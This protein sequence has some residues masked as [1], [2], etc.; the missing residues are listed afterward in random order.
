MSAAGVSAKGSSHCTSPLSL[1]F[2]S[3]LYGAYHL[4]S[5]VLPLSCSAGG[6]MCREGDGG[7]VLA[8]LD[9]DEREDHLHSWPVVNRVLL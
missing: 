8:I 1:I 4:A 9:Q 3:S 2:S 5:R 6:A 7:D